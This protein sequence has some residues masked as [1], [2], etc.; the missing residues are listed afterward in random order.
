VDD[1]KVNW[2]GELLRDKFQARNFLQQKLAAEIH[3]R[4]ELLY[5][6]NDNRKTMNRGSTILTHP[7]SL[8]PHS[9]STR[10]HL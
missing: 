5:E 6:L 3:N 2:S 9:N 7:S 4:K 8:A 1:P 10:S